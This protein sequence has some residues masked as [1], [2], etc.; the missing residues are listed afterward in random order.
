MRIRA[1]A[2]AAGAAADAGA[3]D[4]AAVT[5]SP[6]ELDARATGLTRICSPSSA[7]PPAAAAAARA[8]L[9]P[10]PRGAEH[11]VVRRAAHTLRLSTLI[12]DNP[13]SASGCASRAAGARLGAAGERYAARPDDAFRCRGSGAAEPAAVASASR[14]DAAAAG[15]AAHGHDEGGECAACAEIRAKYAAHDEWLESLKSSAEAVVAANHTRRRSRR[16][17]WAGGRNRWGRTRR[18]HRANTDPGAVQ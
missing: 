4:A 16:R 14:D 8:P 6:S 9:R 7:R 12:P 2:A 10:P 5:P 1:A 17:R 13:G 11:A 15:A 18:T 3:A